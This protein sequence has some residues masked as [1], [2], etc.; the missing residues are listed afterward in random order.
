MALACRRRPPPPP[1]VFGAP[2]VG[3]APVKSVPFW[4]VSG[5]LLR[6]ADVVL[7]VAGASALPSWTTAVP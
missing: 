4:S 5:V 6:C 7:V 3:A 1:P 2:G